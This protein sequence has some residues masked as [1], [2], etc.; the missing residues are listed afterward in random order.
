[1][2]PCRYCDA[3]IVFAWHVRWSRWLPIDP[4]SLTGDEDLQQND[5]GH[6]GVVY[7]RHHRRHMCR[8]RGSSSSS[9]E[10]EE[11]S[12]RARAASAAIWSENWAHRVLFVTSD[13]PP[14]VIR[15]AYK[16]LAMLYHPDHGGDSERM[17]ELNRAYEHLVEKS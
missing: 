9:R 17:L 4:E 3:E 6:L 16:A 15:A 8:S 13:A 14:E 10:A 11:A 12:N 1:M 7:E 5:A 2:L